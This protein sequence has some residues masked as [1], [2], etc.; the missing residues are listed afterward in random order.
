[1]TAGMSESATISPVQAPLNPIGVQRHLPLAP[2][3]LT[4]RITT[5]TELFT[6]AHYGIAQVEVASWRLTIGGMVRKPLSLSLDDIRRLPKR[7]VESFHQCAGFPRR[8][9]I[10]TRRIANVR[11]GGVD[12]AE[13]LAVAE[14]DSGAKFLWSYGLDCGAYESIRG[15]NYQKDMPLAR[16]AEGGVLLAYE[17]NDEPLTAEHGRPL[18][19]IVPGYYGTNCVK[20]LYRL[21][22]ADRR[23]NGMFT[24]LLYNDPVPPSAGHPPDAKVPLW[25]APPESV[26]VFPKSEYVLP[27]DMVEIWGWA[28]G[29]KGIAAVEVSTDGG[30][31]WRRAS[32]DKRS[33][34]SWQRFALSWTPTHSGPVEIIARAVDSAGITQAEDKAR[35]A[36]HRVTVEVAAEVAAIKEQ[37]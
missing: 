29:A 36:M 31:T 17:V 4:D 23:A 34:W 8:H 35:N 16:L 37:T 32:L 26:I 13:L 22:L 15:G 2:H 25:E 33:Q 10:A 1:M 9:D 18:R 24:T 27:R 12:L 5:Q 7:T 30:A 20:W 11:W 21:E 6:I 28:W 14:I 3:Q 19:L